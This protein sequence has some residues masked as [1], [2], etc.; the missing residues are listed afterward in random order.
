MLTRETSRVMRVL[1]AESGGAAWSLLLAGS[2]D[3]PE[4]SSERAQ[5]ATTG[6]S[7]FMGG[8]TIIGCT[9][10]DVCHRTHPG[11]DRH[12]FN[13]FYLLAQ[14]LTSCKCSHILF[15]SDQAD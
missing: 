12:G 15:Q 5:R 8:E 6:Y 11:R 4:S 13:R 10:G 1:S 2:L 9:D 7:F 3:W 14:Q